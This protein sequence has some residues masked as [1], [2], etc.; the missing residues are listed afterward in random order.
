[1]NENLQV[2]ADATR[3]AHTEQTTIGIEL[4]HQG[5]VIAKSGRQIIA[6]PQAA[7]PVLVFGELNGVTRIQGIGAGAR[8]RVDDPELLVLLAEVARQLNK[9]QVLEYVGMVAGVKS[10]AITEHGR[11]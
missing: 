10:M 2:T 6:P 11:T 5:N 7:D 1:M 3:E 9:N 8:V 4:T